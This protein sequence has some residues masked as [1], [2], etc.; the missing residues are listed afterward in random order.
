M[1]EIEF[2]KTNPIF[3]HDSRLNNTIDVIT[4]PRSAHSFRKRSRKG[5]PGSGFPFL[6]SI[7]KPIPKAA[8]PELFPLHGRRTLKTEYKTDSEFTK[9]SVR[10]RR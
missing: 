10:N 7:S 6:L 2:Y 9:K 3:S 4:V 1:T 8:I 5:V